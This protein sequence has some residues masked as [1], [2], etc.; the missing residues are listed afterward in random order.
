[1]LP[2]FACVAFSFAAFALD[3]NELLGRLT[4][5]VPA[6]IALSALQ[7][8]VVAS[9]VPAVAYMAPTTYIV[10]LSY[11]VQLLITLE[12]SIL[13]FWYVL[14]MFSVNTSF[15]YKSRIILNQSILIVYSNSNMAP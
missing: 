9:D 10:V 11:V 5:V 6:A 14:S 4:V 1:M 8:Y 13:K 15:T 7:G 3:V 2:T 12:S